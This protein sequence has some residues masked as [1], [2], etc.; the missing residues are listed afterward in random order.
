[1]AMT[2]HDWLVIAC[3]TFSWWSGF[4]IGRYWFPKEKR[5]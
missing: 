3:A 2:K 4:L 1:M 5:R